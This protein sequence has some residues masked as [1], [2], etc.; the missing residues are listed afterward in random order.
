MD[1]PIYL[2]F[3]VLELSK[4]P[5]Y[6]TYYEKFQPYFTQENNQIHYIDTDAFVLSVNTNDIIRDLKN[7]EHKFDF[8][9]IDKKQ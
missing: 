4:Q 5:M 1:K 3:S 7:L 8:S 9:Y 6:E 2:G